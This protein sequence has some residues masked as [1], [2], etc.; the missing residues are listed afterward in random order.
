MSTF[1]KSDAPL[2]S[3]DKVQKIQWSPTSSR[4]TEAVENN[5]KAVRDAD[6][7]MESL[8]NTSG[9]TGNRPAGIPNTQEDKALVE[10]ALER[11]RENIDATKKR[12]TSVQKRVDVASGVEGSGDR[13]VLN[14][15]KRRPLKRAMRK[16]FG[17]KHEVITP[18]HYKEAIRMKAEL[19]DA[20]AKKHTRGK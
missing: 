3:L 6:K 19:E 10:E 12:I 2:P 15:E 13:F 8:K 9:S 7:R 1:N 14:I 17:G 11:L 4:I 18:E 16:I 5:S 20:S